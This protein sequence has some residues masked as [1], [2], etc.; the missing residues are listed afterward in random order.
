[1][2]IADEKAVY[3]AW[4]VEPIYT[5][6]FLRSSD[7]RILQYPSSIASN[8]LGTFCRTKLCAYGHSVGRKHSGTPSHVKSR[9]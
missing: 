8:L 1:M 6:W 4:D 7:L 9:G 2:I 3:H 5:V